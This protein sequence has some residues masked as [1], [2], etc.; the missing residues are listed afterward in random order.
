MD[1]IIAANEKLDAQVRKLTDTLEQVNKQLKEAN[2]ANKYLQEQVNE[3][4]DELFVLEADR[5]AAQA[6]LKKNAAEQ[7]TLQDELKAARAAGAQSCKDLE[8][9]LKTAKDAGDAFR[10]EANELQQDNDKLAKEK[11]G[12]QKQLDAAQAAEAASGKSCKN[13][14]AQIKQ[15]AGEKAELQKQIKEW[16]EALTKSRN[17]NAKLSNDLKKRK[18]LADA[19]IKD[20]EDALKKY[21]K[22]YEKNKQIREVIIKLRDSITKNEL[23]FD[24]MKK[25]II[26]LYSDLI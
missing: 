6:Q 15:L 17:E 9:K 16:D 23:T 21:E 20:Y 19:A 7:K 25:I 13:L 11:A 14:E 3:K 18:E 24:Q 26:G 8:A 5:D 12:L 2:E 4:A 1:S 22:I 10:E